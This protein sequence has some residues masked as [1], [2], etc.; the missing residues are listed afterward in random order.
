MDLVL[1]ISFLPPSETKA[2]GHKGDVF[3][4][5]LPVCLSRVSQVLNSESIYTMTSL[6]MGPFF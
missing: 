6:P 4:S 5:T 3:L 1:V 2:P